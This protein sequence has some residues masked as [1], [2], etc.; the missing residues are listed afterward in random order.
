MK[1]VLVAILF[2]FV[3]SSAKDANA[4]DCGWSDWTVLDPIKA[5]QVYIAKHCHM[6]STYAQMK[7]QNRN[8]SG[9]QIVWQGSKGGP[10]TVILGPGMYTSPTI[11][12]EAWVS[13]NCGA[14]G[15]FDVNVI[16]ATPR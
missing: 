3:S 8:A 12:V 16:S 7:L 10:Q 5:P 15:W 2:T 1:K 9:F 4:A 6:D 11:E 14:P 13:C